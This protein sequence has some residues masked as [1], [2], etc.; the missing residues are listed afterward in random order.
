MV[1][2]VPGGEVREMDV[3]EL[4]GGECADWRV[5]VGALAE[6]GESVEEGVGVVHA[7]D[8]SGVVKRGVHGVQETRVGGRESGVGGREREGERI[9]LEVQVS[10][11]SWRW[12]C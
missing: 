10:A 6:D 11:A 1:R 7:V 9:R 2:G 3:R 4:G 5:G 12:V 8:G